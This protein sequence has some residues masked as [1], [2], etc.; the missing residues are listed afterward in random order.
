MMMDPVAK[1]V[2]NDDFRQHPSKGVLILTDGIRCN[3]AQD[4]GKIIAKVRN[5]KRFTKGNDPYGE[6]DFGSFMFKGRKIFWKI[7]TYD[8][9]FLY[10]S[11]YIHGV[12]LA[13]KVLT[14]MYAEEY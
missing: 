14:I 12:R 10:I 6:H 1:A 11:P 9:Q 7:D 5:F 4:I 8:T 13:H 2:E 3:S